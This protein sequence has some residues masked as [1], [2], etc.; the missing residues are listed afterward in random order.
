MLRVAKGVKQRVAVLAN[1]ENLKTMS[2]LRPSEAEFVAEAYFLSGV[3]EWGGIFKGLESLAHEKL[4]SNISVGGQGREQS[5]RFVGAL[6]E[7]K[8]WRKLGIN[9]RGEEKEQK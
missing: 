1:P 5:I 4:Q 3:K 6:S 7:S 9:L 2:I 8:I